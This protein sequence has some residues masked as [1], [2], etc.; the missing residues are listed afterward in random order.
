MFLFLLVCLQRLG[1]QSLNLIHVHLHQMS[2]MVPTWAPIDY[3]G[4]WQKRYIN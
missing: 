4:L 1:L 3:S 2:R